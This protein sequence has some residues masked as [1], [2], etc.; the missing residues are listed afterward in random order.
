MPYLAN[1]TAKK[2]LKLNLSGFLKVCLKDSGRLAKLGL[3]HS[4]QITL[5]R[6]HI[7]SNFFE[8]IV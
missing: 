1:K 2:P 6:A 8:L 4:F 7:L 3:L 5:Q